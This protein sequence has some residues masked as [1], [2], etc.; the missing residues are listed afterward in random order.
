MV[1]SKLKTTKGLL[2]DALT[3]TEHLLKSKCNYGLF[4]EKSFYNYLLYL[5]K[6]SDYLNNKD[7]NNFDDIIA[8]VLDWQTNVS[9]TISGAIK[10]TVIDILFII[11]GN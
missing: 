2:N 5:N 4:T 8:G 9:C 10:N 7:I 3:V 6:L 1:L 11:E